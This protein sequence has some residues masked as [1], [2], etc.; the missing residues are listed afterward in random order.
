MRSN[1]KSS[2]LNE[3]S[4]NS[5]CCKSSGMRSPSREIGPSSCYESEGFRDQEREA[6]SKK[7]HMNRNSNVR[8]KPSETLF[9]HAS[10]F[11]DIVQRCRYR[12]SSKGGPD[13]WRFWDGQ[14][15]HGIRRKT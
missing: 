3:D 13:G 12:C 15:S 8:K 4:T 14:G 6:N 9:T 1:T 11:L 10:N 5:K 2:G 7:E